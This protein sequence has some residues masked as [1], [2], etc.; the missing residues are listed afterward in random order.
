[1]FVK[2]KVLFLD[3]APGYYLCGM[4]FVFLLYYSQILYPH[5]SLQSKI[6][7]N[8]IYKKSLKVMQNLPI[9]VAADR[10]NKNIWVESCGGLFRVNG[11]GRDVGLFLITHWSVQ[12]TSRCVTQSCCIVLYTNNNKNL[13]CFNLVTTTNKPINWLVIVCCQNHI[14][15]GAPSFILIIYWS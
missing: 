4:V 11:V 9:Y 7:Y 3:L 12:Q 13:E 10:W 8:F 15:L 6:Y 1:M 2:V 5:Q 14:L